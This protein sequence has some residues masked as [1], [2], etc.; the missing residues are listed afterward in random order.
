MLL[1]PL[2]HQG[3]YIMIYK[4]VRPSIVHRHHRHHFHHY[5]LDALTKNIGSPGWFEGELAYKIL[6]HEVAMIDRNFT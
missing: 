4:C 5:S 6:P 3:R 1:V 2:V